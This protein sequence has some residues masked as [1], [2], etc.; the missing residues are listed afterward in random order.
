[1][2]AD[3]LEGRLGN[4]AH[5]RLVP[6]L[7]EEARQ[8]PVGIQID[9]SYSRFS[10]ETSFDISNQLIYGTANAVY[11]FQSSA[12]TRIRPYLIGG[13]GVYNSKETGDDALGGS[14]TKFG[15]NGGAGVDFKAG[16][17]GLF[18]EARFHNVFVTGP[19]VEFFPLNLGIRFGGG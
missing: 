7:R 12:D 9:G 4:P 13:V 19:N 14:S 18:L 3:L 11:R 5:E 8:L 10:D 15:V 6:P 17:A 1:M 2:L 16:G